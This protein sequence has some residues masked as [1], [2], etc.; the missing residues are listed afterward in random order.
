MTPYPGRIERTLIEVWDALAQ[1]SPS[2]ALE[3][4]PGAI[5]PLVAAVRGLAAAVELLV[6]EIKTIERGKD[7]G[8]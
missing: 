8:T 5:P 6:E 7:N 3:A 1:C 2:G 4:R